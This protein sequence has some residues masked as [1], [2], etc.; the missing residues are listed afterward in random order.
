MQVLIHVDVGQMTGGVPEEL[1]RRIKISFDIQVCIRK[2]LEM[3]LNPFFLK[4]CVNCPS[5][6]TSMSCM[7]H[8]L[9][10]KPIELYLNG[11]SSI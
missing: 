10:Q 9:I 4:Q 11:S 3:K 2:D 7:L 5:W 8:F 6:V 1:L